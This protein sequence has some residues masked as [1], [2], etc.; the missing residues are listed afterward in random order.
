MFNNIENYLYI[1][2]ESKEGYLNI[3]SFLCK[4]QDNQYN[5]KDL[6]K[7]K[8]FMITKYGYVILNNKTYEIFSNIVVVNMNIIAIKLV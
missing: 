6:I 4:I 8:N 3:H 1:W 5:Y 7:T 2:D